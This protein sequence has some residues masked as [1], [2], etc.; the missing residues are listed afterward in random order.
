MN[1]TPLSGGAFLIVV[2]LPKQ[3]LA[4]AVESESVLFVAALSKME[5]P[6]PILS[7]P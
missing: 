7:E 3:Q 5:R 6:R 1:E 2:Q 4:V